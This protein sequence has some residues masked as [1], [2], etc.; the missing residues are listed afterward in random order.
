MNVLYKSEFKTIEYQPKN[1]MIVIRWLPSTATIDEKTFKSEVTISLKF[2]LEHKPQRIL[3]DSSL[4]NFVMAP[5][6]QEWL[7]NEVFTVYPK[8]NVKRKAFLVTSDL[9]TQVSLQQ[10]IEDAKNQTFESAFFQSEEDA[11]NW[12]IKEI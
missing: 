7:D 9:F 12:L 1:E 6:T 10:H 11:L 4:F 3:I 2:I 8:A 5:Q